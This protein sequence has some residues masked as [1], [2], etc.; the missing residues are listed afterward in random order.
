MVG[1][2]RG[3][4]LIVSIVGDHNNVHNG[5]HDENEDDL[6]SPSHSSNRTPRPQESE[7]QPLTSH[8]EFTH[9]YGTDSSSSINIMITRPQTP[10]SPFNPLHTRRKKHTTPPKYILPVDITS[11]DATL[12]QLATIK[13][14]PPS[15]QSGDDDDASNSDAVE[16]NHE[17]HYLKSKLWL[18]FYFPLLFFCSFGFS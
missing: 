11:E 7:L 16:L 3:E 1:M 14:R 18:A 10:R 5:H 6:F 8:P 4:I 15:S 2:D 17:G 9:D 12:H 13:R